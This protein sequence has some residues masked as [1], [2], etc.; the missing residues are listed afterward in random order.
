MN[1]YIPF[2]IAFVVTNPI[3]CV[4]KALYSAFGFED[5]FPM[6][7]KTHLVG[8]P[9]NKEKKNWSIMLHIIGLYIL[10]WNRDHLLILED[11]MI[12]T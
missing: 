11:T 7:K 6:K 8:P 12:L 10:L 5:K 3:C 4:M 1:C 2:S 9:F